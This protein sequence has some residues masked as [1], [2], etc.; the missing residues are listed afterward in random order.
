MSNKTAINWNIFLSIMSIVFF[1]GIAYA[2]VSNNKTLIAGVVSSVEKIEK[3]E[4]LTRKLAIANSKDII[5]T[6]KDVESCEIRL[7]LTVGAVN[8]LVES[9][10]RLSKIIE[11]HETIL[12]IYESRLKEK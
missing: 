8:K 7:G 4:N 11:S 5:S 10:D 6:N 9:T 1:A 2:T 12:G 3:N